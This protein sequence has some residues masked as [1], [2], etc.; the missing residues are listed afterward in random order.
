MAFDQ[1][2][3]NSSFVINLL[4][5]GNKSLSSD[6]KQSR[7]NSIIATSKTTRTFICI[8]LGFKN[9]SCHSNCLSRHTSLMYWVLWNA[10]L[11]C[12]S[13]LPFLPFLPSTFFLWV[14]Q[15][16]L[17]IVIPNNS[18]KNRTSEFHPVQSPEKRHSS[19]AV[20]WFDCIRALLTPVHIYCL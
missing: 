16:Q 8:S 6:L 17:I 19:A 3:F 1:T 12:H 2:I 4:V 10:Y 11:S 20:L 15:P 18:R 9:F 5:H 13:S 14:S 7:N